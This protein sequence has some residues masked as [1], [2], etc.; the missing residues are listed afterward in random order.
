LIEEAGILN[1]DN[2]NKKNVEILKAY[3]KALPNGK[4]AQFAEEVNQYHEAETKPSKEAFEDY[5]EKWPDGKFEKWAKDNLASTSLGEVKDQ[6]LVEALAKTNRALLDEFMK[7]VAKCEKDYAGTV[8]EIRLLDRHTCMHIIRDSL[9][10]LDGSFNLNLTSRHRR[11]QA[12]YYY[13]NGE[14]SV[15]NLKFTLRGG[16]LSIPKFDKDLEIVSGF[17][18]D[19]S[20]IRDGK[21]Y[22]YNGSHWVHG[23]DNPFFPVEK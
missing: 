16:V 7:I 9:V 6:L 18:E 17:T 23:M 20:V 11:F 10:V 3:L 13:Y 5:L 4:H 12:E 15:G 22:H 19:S 8:T 21:Q 14:V 2:L 1:I